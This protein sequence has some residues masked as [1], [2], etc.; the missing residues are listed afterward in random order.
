MEQLSCP[1]CLSI[2]TSD[3]CNGC[4]SNLRGYRLLM[5]LPKRSTGRTIA[6]NNKFVTTNWQYFY[7]SGLIGLAIGATSAISFLSKPEQSQSIPI[8]QT[9]KN[10]AVDVQG[11]EKRKGVNA[12]DD[13]IPYNIQA[14]DTLSSIASKYNSEKSIETI[15]QL[16]PWLGKSPD[17]LYTGNYLIVPKKGIK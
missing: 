11:N 16:N 2:L 10:I 6:N 17:V 12:V 3:H 14:G 15:I 1:V 4:R 7:I 5:N 13:V 9:L 8:T